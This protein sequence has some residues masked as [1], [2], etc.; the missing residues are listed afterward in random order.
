MKL[1]LSIVLLAVVIAANASPT[2]STDIDEIQE[3]LVNI[4]TFAE[5]LEIMEGRLDTLEIN[6]QGIL[7]AEDA[8]VS[9]S[10]NPWIG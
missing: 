7:D 5:D 6:K 9:A 1:D 3:S 2:P 8:V 10:I 4:I